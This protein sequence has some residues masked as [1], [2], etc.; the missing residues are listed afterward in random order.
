MDTLGHCRNTVHDHTYALAGVHHLKGFVYKE[1]ERHPSMLLIQIEFFCPIENAVMFITKAHAQVVWHLLKSGRH[2]VA[3]EGDTELLN[4]LMTYVAHEVHTG[5]DNCEFYPVQKDV[6]HDPHGNMWF[7]LSAENRANVY[8]FLFLNTRPKLKIEDDY[9]CRRDVVIGALDGF[10]G[11]STEAAANFVEKVEEC[12]FDNGKLELTLNYYKAQFTEE[13]NFNANDEEEVSEGQGP[14]D[15][16]TVYH[17]YTGGGSN[18]PE[19]GFDGHKGR[20]LR[21][22]GPFA[23]AG[24][25]RHRSLHGSAEQKGDLV[26][27]IFIG[28]GSIRSSAQQPPC[29]DNT[30]APGMEEKVTPPPETHCR[31][32][33][34]GYVSQLC[35]RLPD[36][37]PSKVLMATVVSSQCNEDG[38]VAMMEAEEVTVRRPIEDDLVRTLFHEFDSPVVISPSSQLLTPQDEVLAI[39]G[40]GGITGCPVELNPDAS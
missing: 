11:A 17:K 22:G 9:K 31:G 23:G 5:V 8:K 21:D 24:C 16:E 39:R 35:S 14:L 30:L 12:Y 18:F 33:Q 34:R 3:I 13:D 15:L 10:Y 27:G 19:M 32:S 25:I 1:M 36:M 2:I 20:G 26:I 7:K 38:D 6:D 28:G 40:S 4:F 37:Q 29:T